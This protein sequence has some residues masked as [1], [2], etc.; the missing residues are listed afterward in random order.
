MQ[1]RIESSMSGI[2]TAMAAIAPAPI[3]TVVAAEL[4]AEL[5]AVGT[6]LS[7][8]AALTCAGVALSDAIDVGSSP[9]MAGDA[10]VSKT[11][12]VGVESR[13]AEANVK[14]VVMLAVD[15]LAIV[16]AAMFAGIGRSTMDLE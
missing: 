16:M 8:D 14:I 2:P 5:T 11:R 4:N 12:S 10:F 9:E 3:D 1:A 15:E 6:E 13:A 7:K